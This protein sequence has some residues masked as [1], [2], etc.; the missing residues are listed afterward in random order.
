MA[1]YRVKDCRDMSLCLLLS[2]VVNKGLLVNRTHNIGRYLKSS[3]SVFSIYET[4]IPVLIP[5][6]QKQ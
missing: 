1:T 6:F 2:P 3:V 5:L 4:E